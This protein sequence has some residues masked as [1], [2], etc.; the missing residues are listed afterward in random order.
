MISTLSRQ[1]SLYHP[2]TNGIGPV[3][4]ESASLLSNG[5]EELIIVTGCNKSIFTKSMGYGSFGAVNGS[6]GNFIF[7]AVISDPLGE[8]GDVLTLGGV[9]LTMARINTFYF[10][11]GVYV[12]TAS[13]SIINTAGLLGTDS[14]VFE[15]YRMEIQQHTSGGYVLKTCQYDDS[16]I[17]ITS[18]LN[19]QGRRITQNE[20]KSLVFYEKT[21]TIES[22]GFVYLGGMPLIY[23]QIG[24]NNYLTI[25][26]ST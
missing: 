12:V 1:G 9:D 7:S 17:D 22:T 14:F 25:V 13:S 23:V 10:S 20:N 19:I 11:L 6:N 5:F 15:G 3:C 16:V 4:S 21:G 8:Q 18:Y 24:G 26:Q 2:R